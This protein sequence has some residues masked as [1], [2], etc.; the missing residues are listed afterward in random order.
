V[1]GTIALRHE[2]MIPLLENMCDEISRNGLKKI[3]IVN[4]HG[5]NTGL[6]KYFLDIILDKEKDYM[7]YASRTIWEEAEF[8]KVQEAK[9]DGHGGEKETSYM[10]YLRPELVKLDAFKD[11][12]QP[13]KRISKFSD[14]GLDSAIGWYSN[15]PNHFAGEKVSFTKEKGKVLIDG[16]IGS[17]VK[18]IQLVKKDNTPFELYKEYSKRKHKPE[19]Q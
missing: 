3:I 13:Q 10:L 19:N 9:I 15:F 7:V 2:L 11:N 8:K 14:T 17:I 6:L 16:H 1:P 5:G 4:G 18:Q 12:G